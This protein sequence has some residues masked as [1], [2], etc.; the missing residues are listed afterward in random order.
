MGALES[1]IDE[2]SDPRFLASFEWTGPHSTCPAWIH[3]ANPA[4]STP[5]AGDSCNQDR[6]RITT[7]RCCCRP[8]GSSQKNGT[9]GATSSCSSPTRR[10]YATT[11]ASPVSAYL[12][13]SVPSRSVLCSIRQ[14]GYP[15]Q[16]EPDVD[17]ILGSD[18]SPHCFSGVFAWE[19]VL[20]PAI[21]GIGLTTPWYRLGNGTSTTVSPS[22]STV[23]AATARHEARG[24]NEPDGLRVGCWAL[25]RVCRN[26]IKI[27]VQRSAA[28]GAALRHRP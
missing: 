22:S 19:F 9:A 5:T 21:E 26:G 17:P 25:K 11:P 20:P 12:I 14:R 4:S 2:P 1:R 15:E 6:G 8:P 3:A 27:P 18:V 13:G 7:C 10:S 23:D 24:V 16:L 28:L